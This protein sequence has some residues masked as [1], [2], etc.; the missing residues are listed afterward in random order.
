V[1]PNVCDLHSPVC[2]TQE[3]PGH[4]HEPLGEIGQWIHPGFTHHTMR[5]DNLANGY[6]LIMTHG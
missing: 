5:T 6:E 2:A 1:L 4:P 3:Y